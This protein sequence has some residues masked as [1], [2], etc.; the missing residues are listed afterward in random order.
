MW[1]LEEDGRVRRADTDGDGALDWEEYGAVEGGVELAV[2]RDHVC[3]RTDKGAMWC[4][5]HNTHGQLGDGTSER[6]DD[7]VPTADDSVEAI[8]LAELRSCAVVGDQLACAGLAREEAVS[9]ERDPSA[10]PRQ[11]TIPKLRARALA[12]SADTTCALDQ[13]GVV[14]CWGLQALDGKEN[15]RDRLGIV[16]VSTP[17][18][19]SE[20]ADDLRGLWSRDEF[21][22]WL[23]GQGRLRR[24]FW[25]LSDPDRPPYLEAKSVGGAEAP[26]G[27][28]V[29]D[30]FACTTEADTSALACGVVV[31]RRVPVP[32]IKRALAM[33]LDFRTVCAITPRHRVRCAYLP[34]RYEE[35]ALVISSTL[36]RLKDVVDIASSGRVFCALTRDGGVRCW[37]V[38]GRQRFDARE[39]L[40]LAVTFGELKDAGLA[41]VTSLVGNE[42]G[43]AS[44]DGEGRVRRWDAYYGD[45]EDEPAPKL[46]AAAVELVAGETH[47][48][49]RDTKHAV[50]CWGAEDH[51]Q[52]GRLPPEVHLELHPLA[53]AEP[54]AP[55]ATR[56]SSSP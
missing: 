42:L 4:R 20:R 9:P 44:L 15:K 22:D 32:G 45:L 12:A 7:F 10:P 55:A 34:D 52:L 29:G 31:D 8:A 33:T 3:V 56:A 53:L 18:V 26:L 43:F 39:R 38:N 28:L 2:A 47:F 37:S 40:Q 5:G 49:A 17:T 35:S 19:V 13:T 16:A 23:D 6:R 25:A 48:C 11:H 1:I 50:T 24:N 36:P 46:D 30:H 51:G 54:G 21:F 27:R 14:R 41:D